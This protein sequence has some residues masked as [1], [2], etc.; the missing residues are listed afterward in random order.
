MSSVAFVGSDGIQINGIPLIGFS[1]GK[2]V[3]LDY[4][5]D[6]INMTIGK[7]GSMVGAKNEAGAQ[8]ECKLRLLIG[9]P[10]DRYLNSLMLQQQANP[11]GFGIITG[12]FAKVV[13]TD[14]G[15][16]VA[17]YSLSRGLIRKIP[18]GQDDTQGDTEQAIVEWEILFAQ[19]VRTV[20]ES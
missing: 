5:N 12:V 6:L 19:S 18:G 3:L 14:G 15:T 2:A 9:S 11:S 20:G 13:N 4:P 10:G 1:N 7:D 17:R 8:V 16:Q